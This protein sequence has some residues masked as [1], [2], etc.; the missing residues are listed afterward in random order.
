MEYETVVC[1]FCEKDELYCG[2]FDRTCCCW[3]LC[4]KVWTNVFT[5]L[6]RIYHSGYLTSQQRNKQN[7]FDNLSA[8]AKY[9]IK[10]RS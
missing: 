1:L 10:T 2:V 4:A 5:L 6:L 8:R 9:E 3:S 7:T